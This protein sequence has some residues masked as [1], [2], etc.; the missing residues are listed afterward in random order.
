MISMSSASTPL[1][2]LTILVACSAGKMFEL[3][4]GLRAMGGTILPFPV[5]D[6]QEIDDKHLL[7]QALS[8]LREYSWILFTSANGV[9][10]FMQR[11]REHTLD[12]N[13]RNMPKLCAI[14]PATAA[15]LKEFGC[16]ASLIPESYQ[17]EGVLEALEK[18]HGGIRN[19]AGKRVLLPRAK[20][21]RELLPQSLISAGVTVDVVPCYQ[22]VKGSIDDA[23]LRQLKDKAPDLM[24]FTSSSTIRNLM[25]TLGPEEGKR[26]L[27]RSTVA[28]LGPVTGNTARSF[29]KNAE[30]VPRENTIP[31]LMEAIEHYYKAV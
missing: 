28:V 18:Y 25:E 11:A 7:D 22:T 26:L 21:A 12:L 5:I 9:R 10:F 3:A 13:G 24:V 31:A 27:C 1:R 29:G 14:G 15:E 20:E 6:I 17:A 2:N 30:I 4:S 19:L 16:E 23:V 8:S